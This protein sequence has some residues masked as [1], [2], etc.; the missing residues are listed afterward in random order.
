[1][2]FYEKLAAFAWCV[3]AV[4]AVVGVLLLVQYL[5]MIAESLV[6]VSESLH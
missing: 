2:F 4:A 5:P 1:M 3:I 6:K